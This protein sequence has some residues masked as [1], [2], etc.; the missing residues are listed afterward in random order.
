MMI[1][2]TG[3]P[4]TPSLSRRERGFSTTIAPK[5]SPLPPEGGEGEGEGGDSRA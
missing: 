3:T 1:E 5:I 4:L 2:G